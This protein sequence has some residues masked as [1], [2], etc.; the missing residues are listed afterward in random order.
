[1][2][3]MDFPSSAGGDEVRRLAMSAS[4]SGAVRLV[5]APVLAYKVFPDGREE[6]VRGLRFRGLNVR[7]LRDVVAA[8]EE[9]YA[10]HYLNNM[11][12]MALMSA[13][14]PTPRTRYSCPCET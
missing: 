11:A 14:R 13:R 1:M 6:L 4:Q 2:R 12:P 10:L 3:K 8:S 7:A 9:M 5:S